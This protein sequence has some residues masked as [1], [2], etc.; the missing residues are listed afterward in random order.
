LVL[1]PGSRLGVYEVG[2]PIGAG[3]MGE[4]YK[5][6]DTRLGR[7]VA[8]V[9]RRA[10]I[11]AFGSV[12]FEMLTGRRAFPSDDE[13]DTIVSVVSKEPDWNGL[14][15]TL[16]AGVRRLLRRC[17]EKDP[18]RRLDSAAPVRIES[19]DALSAPLV[20]PNPSTAASLEPRARAVA[21]RGGHST[22]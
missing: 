13:T 4:V 9:D 6:R 18:K 8:I 20:D 10:G 5:G 22:I 7:P 1:T 2:A 21:R 12:L 19:E 11:W 3:G 15:S 14:P 16:P 17:V